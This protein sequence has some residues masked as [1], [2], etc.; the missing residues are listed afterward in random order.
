MGIVR[1]LMTSSP[2]PCGGGAGGEGA[3]AKA[4]VFPPS[5]QPLSREGRG[6]ELP[7][8]CGGSW[9]E[10]PALQPRSSRRRILPTGVFGSSARN[11]T[12]LGRL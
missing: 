7:G 4:S 12:I 8:S 1:P 6:A 9:A 11:S 10:P 5:P 2:P 3:S